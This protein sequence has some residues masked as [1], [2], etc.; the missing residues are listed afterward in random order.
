MSLLEVG[1]AGLP[2]GAASEPEPETAAEDGVLEGC[3]ALEPAEADFGEA[4][5]CQSQLLRLIEKD[6]SGESREKSYS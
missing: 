6:G 2:V 1:A 3:D 4:A 5:R